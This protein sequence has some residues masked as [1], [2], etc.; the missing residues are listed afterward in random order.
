M[1]PGVRERWRRE[2]KPLWVYCKARGIS[3]AAAARRCAANGKLPPLTNLQLSQ[4]S[5]ARVAAPAGFIRE[6]CAE[7]ERPVSVVM[8]HDAAWV[9]EF[10][11]KYG[12]AQFEPAAPA[13]TE[14]A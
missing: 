3:V 13:P 7:I 10:G 12:V 1:P 6:M 8:G 4:I 14:A 9:A 5:A 11:A 2:V